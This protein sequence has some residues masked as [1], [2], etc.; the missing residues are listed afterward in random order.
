MTDREPTPFL[1]NYLLVLACQIPVWGCGG[2]LWGVFMVLLAG[3]HP[4]SG[5]IGGLV[6]G[7]AMWLIL[8][9]LFAVGL[10][11][12]RSAE[13]PTADR[14]AIEA[15]IEPVC[16][17]LRLA[18]R[19]EDEDEEEIVLGP[20]RALV[21]FRLQET[22]IVFADGTATLTGPALTFGSIRK[23]LTRALDDAV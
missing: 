3:M 9:N 13:L 14:G 2:L 21:Q 12:R 22:Q 17:K 23:A 18:V 15:A 4:V 5:L 19:Y 6:W 16:A 1:V 10:A 7:F 8:G 11:W 20:K